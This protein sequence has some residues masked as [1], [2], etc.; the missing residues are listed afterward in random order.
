[1]GPAEQCVSVRVSQSKTPDLALSSQK[2]HDGCRPFECSDIGKFFTMSSALC[3]YQR[4]HQEISFV[5]VVNVG[6]LFS[7]AVTSFVIIEF[8]QREC[9]YTC[10]EYGKSF[11]L[12]Q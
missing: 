5:S 11:F 10:S 3:Y 4:V 6:S 9:P 8:T 7:I 12:R 2:G 1:M